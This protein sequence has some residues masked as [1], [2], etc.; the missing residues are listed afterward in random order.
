MIF[1]QTPIWGN[2]K[3]EKTYVRYKRQ[4]HLLRFLL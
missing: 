2:F 3:E 1:V 4:L